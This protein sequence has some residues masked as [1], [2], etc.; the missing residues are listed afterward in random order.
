MRASRDIMGPESNRKALILLS[1]GGE[2]GSVATGAEAVEAALRADT[3]V[4]SIFFKG[5]GPDGREN[6]AVLSRETGGSY[7]EVSKQRPIDDVFAGIEDELRGQY[8]IG[9]VSNHPLRQATFRRI[10]VT[11][12]RPQAKVQ[13]RS[14]YWAAI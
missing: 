12:T 2:N 8:S 9:Y 3:L 10:E 4:Y 13:S 14:R 5:R 6:L 1:D 11:T 7:F